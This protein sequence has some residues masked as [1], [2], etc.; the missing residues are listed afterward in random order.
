MSR[1]LRQTNWNG[2][3][4]RNVTAGDWYK[5]LMSRQGSVLNVGIDKGELLIEEAMKGYA[6][7]YR[8]KGANSSA[9]LKTV[10]QGE[11]MREDNRE[12]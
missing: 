12:I 10:V 9:E 6:L 1:I 7:Y 3:T 4:F 8:M 11:D 2:L 5:E